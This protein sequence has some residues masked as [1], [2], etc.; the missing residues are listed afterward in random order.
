[1]ETSLSKFDK[2]FILES[3][4]KAFNEYLYNYNI[5]LSLEAVDSEASEKLDHYN[6]I[7][8]NIQTAEAKK[9]FLE[10]TLAELLASEE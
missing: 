2:I 9:A 5:D 6:S 7:R 8:A 3:K 4:I 1:M 10:T